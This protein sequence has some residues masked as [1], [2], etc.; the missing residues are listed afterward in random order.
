MMDDRPQTID[1]GRR[2][3]GPPASLWR[4][5]I[6][7]ILLM[8]LAFAVSGTASAAPARQAQ[9]PECQSCHPGE[10]DV[11]K[12]SKHAGAGLDP[13]FQGQLAKAHNQEECLTCHTT[14]VETGSGKAMA[15]GVTCPA[16]HGT[17]QAGHFLRDGSQPTGTTMKLPVKSSATCRTCHKAAFAGWET[18]KHAEKKIECFDCHL[19]HTQG[20]R[21]GSVDTL[22]AACH[23]DRGTQAAHSRH[24]INGVNSRAA[25]CPSR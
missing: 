15:D 19:A 17:Y 25:T 10:Y 16:C 24:G 18:S 11:W 7:P 13:V 4:L 8:L 3:E 9:E 22:C 2:A 12:S 1:H 23:S 14:G 6:T 5:A 20:V 21:T